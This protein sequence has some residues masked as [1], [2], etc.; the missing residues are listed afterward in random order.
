MD[1]KKIFVYGTLKQ[2]KSNHHYYLG[3]SKFL[4]EAKTDRDI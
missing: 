2:G 3:E 1:M 4:G